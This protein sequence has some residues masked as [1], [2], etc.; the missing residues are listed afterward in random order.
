MYQEVHTENIAE[1]AHATEVGEL[2]QLYAQHCEAAR[3]IDHEAFAT[4]IMPRFGDDVMV[5]APTGDGE[6]TY[7]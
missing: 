2:L 1:R 7:V 6:Y 3:V 5:I 4:A